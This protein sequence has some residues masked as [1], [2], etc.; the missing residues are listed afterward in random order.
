MSRPG[1]WRQWRR[2]EGIV[3][4]DDQWMHAFPG[5]FGEGDHAHQHFAVVVV[6][7]HFSRSDSRCQRRENFAGDGDDVLLL[8]VNFVE[9]TPEGFHT[10]GIAHRDEDRAGMLQTERLRRRFFGDGFIE[11][12]K[13]RVMPAAAATV[14]S[15][16]G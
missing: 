13:V 16:P 5:F 2:R 12:F 7:T 8:G 15:A 11:L 9:Q 10:V 14:E 3:G 6:N 4:G 1:F